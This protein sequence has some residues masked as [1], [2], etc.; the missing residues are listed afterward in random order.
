MELTSKQNVLFKLIVLLLLIVILSKAMYDSGLWISIISFAPILPIYLLL[1]T[2]SQ[3]IFHLK[4]QWG[5]AIFFI[6]IIQLGFT[7]VALSDLL[8]R[9]GLTSKM[10]KTIILLAFLIPSVYLYYKKVKEITGNLKN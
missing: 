2:T 3:K 1:F 5:Y 6:V 7:Q 10:Y 4:K 8:L 9:L